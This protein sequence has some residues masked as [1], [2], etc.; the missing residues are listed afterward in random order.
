VGISQRM[1]REK[2]SAG[3]G[4]I[5]YPSARPATS[6]RR[7][8]AFATT[9]QVRRDQLTNARFGAAKVTVNVASPR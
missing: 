3:K 7:A 6:T 4:V 2:V 9:L 1:S 8:G 5:S